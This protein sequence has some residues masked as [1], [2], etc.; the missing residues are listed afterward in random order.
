MR[1]KSGMQVGGQNVNKENKEYQV[2]EDNRNIQES[3]RKNEKKTDDPV[4]SEANPKALE[5]G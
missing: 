1:Q 5:M 4:G 2:K 3:V